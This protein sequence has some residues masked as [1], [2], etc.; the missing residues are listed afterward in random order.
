MKKL[1][2]LFLFIFFLSGCSIFPL[3]KETENTLVSSNNAQFIA[4]NV[5]EQQENRIDL[6]MGY[7][8]VL[9]ERWELVEHKE[10]REY[11]ITRLTDSTDPEI[12]T[13]IKYYQSDYFGPAVG[14]FVFSIDPIMSVSNVAQMI[15]YFSCPIKNSSEQ[16]QINSLPVYVITGSSDFCDDGTEIFYKKYYTFK[17]EGRTET[18]A[19]IFYT[20]SEEEYQKL[21]NDLEDILYS[22]SRNE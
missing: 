7:S 13:T 5:S 10:Y 2:F 8:F 9:S 21:K 22:V 14:F 20:K 18:L 1:Y 6:G 11:F 12:D 17:P 4:T 19:V 15:R 16:L 3:K